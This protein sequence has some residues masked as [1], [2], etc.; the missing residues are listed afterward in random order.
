MEDGQS[1]RAELWNRS[2]ALFDRVE[3]TYLRI[4][5]GFILIFATLLILYAAWLGVSSLY[6]ISRSTNGIVEEVATVQGQDLLPAEGAEVQQQPRG[7]Q[8]DRTNPAHQRFYQQFLR[9]YH[10]LFRQRFEPFRQSVDRQLSLDAFD[11][12]YLNT[13]RRLQEIGRGTLS[14]ESDR[15]DLELLM[16]AMTQASQAPETHR[17]LATY[18]AARQVRVFREVQRRRAVTRSGWDR[19]STACRDWFYPPYGCPVTRTVQQPYTERV[20]ELRFPEGTRSHADIFRAYHERFFELLEQ[21][22]MENAGQAQSARE[23]ILMGQ[24]DGR[25][26]L[27]QAA[28]IFVGFL[29]V[30]FFFLLIAI[31]RH[32]RRLA[33]ALATQPETVGKEPEPSP[34]AT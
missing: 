25:L 26:S 12:A 32:Q 20:S 19:Y 17:R 8:G 18:R 5:R 7:D 24:I 10:A 9:R 28:Y 22:R 13:D 30:M 34:A 6:K 31:E 15:N 2:G 29:A 3:A 1:S 21:R 14:F 27:I 33:S 4:L 16:V 23:G 11:D